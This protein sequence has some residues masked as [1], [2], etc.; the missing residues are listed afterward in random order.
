MTCDTYSIFPPCGLPRR[1]KKIS[2][3][4]PKRELLLFLRSSNDV[5]SS[6]PPPSPR[7]YTTHLSVLALPNASSRGLDPRIMSFTLCTSPSPPLTAA[8]PSRHTSR[9]A[10]HTSHVTRHTCNVAHDLLGG[11]RLARARLPRYNDAPAIVT[12]CVCKF[13]C[14]CV[15]KFQCNCVCKFQCNCVFNPMQLWVARLT[16]APPP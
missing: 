16:A 2:K 11:L 10:R 8:V 6:P 7:H 4:L 5:S 15:F 1:S 12:I 13:Q 3:Y 9:V 14:N